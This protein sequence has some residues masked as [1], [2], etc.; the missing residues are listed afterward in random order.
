M[1]TKENKAK[2]YKKIISIKQ[3]FIHFLKQNNAYE[4]YM[5]S[6]NK[7]YGGV[8]FESLIKTSDE[9]CYVSNAFIWNRTPEGNLFWLEINDQWVKLFTKSKDKKS[10]HD[11][12]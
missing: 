10:K 12:Y 8:S 6:L 9:N 5:R 7:K 4:K 2:K 1:N 3:L 11:R